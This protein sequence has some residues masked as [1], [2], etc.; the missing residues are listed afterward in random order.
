MLNQCLARN[1]FEQP[2]LGTWRDIIGIRT[3]WPIVHVM[4]RDGCVYFLM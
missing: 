4:I 1:T 3:A 2:Y